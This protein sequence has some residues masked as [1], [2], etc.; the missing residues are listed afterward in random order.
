M[1]LPHGAVVAIV[2]GRNFELYRNAG[3]EAEPGLAALPSPRLDTHNH[4]GGS[5]HGRSAN[6][7]SHL[8]DEDAHAIAVVEWLNTEVLA[9]RLENLVV[10]AAPRTLGEMRRHYHK[11]TERAMV[12]EIAK[13]LAGRPPADILTALRDRK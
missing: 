9:H 13:D 4:S 1:L 10:I 11:L 8:A 3:N 7:E 12:A 6:H 5:H 2:D